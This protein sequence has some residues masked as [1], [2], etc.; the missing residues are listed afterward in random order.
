MIQIH[1]HVIGVM[2]QTKATC[3]LSE[4]FQMDPKKLSDQLERQ[5]IHY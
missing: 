3:N 2:K 4:F 5:F 1:E